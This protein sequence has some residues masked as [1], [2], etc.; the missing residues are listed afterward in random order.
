MKDE[1]RCDRLLGELQIRYGL[2]QPFLA[3]V[4]PIAENILTMD[5]PEGKRTE[6][7]EMLAETCQRDYSIRCATAA[8]QEAWQGFMDDLARIAEV[9]Y[10]RRKQ[11]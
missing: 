6:L 1:Q 9:L 5:L 8:A 11:G 7:L 2:K 10:R 3:R 4:R